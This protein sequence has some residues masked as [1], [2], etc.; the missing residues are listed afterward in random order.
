[1]IITPN[2]DDK[3]AS[4]AEDIRKRYALLMEQT[5]KPYSASERETWSCQLAEADAWLSDNTAPTP[6]LSALATNRGIS[7]TVLVS[8]V[9][10]KDALYRTNI[11]KLLGEQQQ[12][13]DMLYGK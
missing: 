8:K 12:E 1:M 2:I 3:R 9:K 7:L 10:K 11:G 6:L 5:V 4:I 13:L